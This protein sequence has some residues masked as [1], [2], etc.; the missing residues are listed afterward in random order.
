MPIDM[1]T[2]SIFLALLL[3]VVTGTDVTAFFYNKTP[4][5]LTL[6]FFTTWVGSFT[7]NPPSTVAPYSSAQW[8]L[9]SAGW[10]GYG[11]IEYNVY[12]TR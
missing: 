11:L 8:S 10:D 12:Y 5:S 2:T 7:Q 6:Y 9:T 3:S 1:T 4:A